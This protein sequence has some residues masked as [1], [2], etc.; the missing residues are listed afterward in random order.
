MQTPGLRPIESKGDI[1]YRDENGV[2]NWI[3]QEDR[4]RATNAFLRDARTYA[5][6][7]GFV[8]DAKDQMEKRLRL[9][10]QPYAKEVMIEYAVSLPQK[11]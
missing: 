4:T 11:D 8:Q 10:L 5:T 9:L 2:W 7:A 6:R 3:D 1:S